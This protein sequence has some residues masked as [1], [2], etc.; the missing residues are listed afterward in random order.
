MIISINFY[1]DSIINLK[2]SG[3]LIIMNPQIKNR[4]LVLPVRGVLTDRKFVAYKRNIKMQMVMGLI[5][6]SYQ[7]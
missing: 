4:G 3:N 1:S 7:R 2:N 6:L 5:C